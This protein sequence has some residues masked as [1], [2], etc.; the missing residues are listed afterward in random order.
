MRLVAD[1]SIPLVRELF[2]GFGELILLPGREIAAVDVRDAD[3]LLVRS[4]TRVDRTL[5]AGSRLR[6]VASATI[7]TDHVDQRALHELGIAFANAPGCNANAVAEYVLASLWVLAARDKFQPG[8]DVIG[9]LGLGNVGRR[10]AAKFDAL[11]WPYRV[12]DPPLAEQLMHLHAE[13][14]SKP[15]GVAAQPSA[16]SLPP[17]EQWLSPAALLD[18]DVLSLHVPLVRAGLHATWHWLAAEQFERMRA[19][20]IINSCRGPVV[21]NAALLTWLQADA[22]RAA[23]LDV[24]EHEPEVPDALLA[25]VDIATPHIAGHS[26]EGKCN[27]SFMIHEAFCRQFAVDGSGAA[28]WQLAPAGRATL[29]ERSVDLQL[30]DQL[31]HCYDPRR[32]DNALRTALAAAPDRAR[33]FDLLRKHYPERRE[34][35]SWQFQASASVARR[36]AALA[37]FQQ[38]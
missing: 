27:G 23:V 28:A 13:V 34:L 1:E 14:K 24:W 10:L 7:G 8:R 37:G 29:S 20:V 25:N 6:F 5:V 3:A 32:D 11:Q 9:I 18:C 38:D 36:Y 4:V 16:A 12:S 22:H 15:A 35:L 30:R 2:G 21:D 31:L 19:R 17:P 26:R 33:A